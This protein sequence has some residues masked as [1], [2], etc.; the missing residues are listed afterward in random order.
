MGKLIIIEGGDG[1]G[2]ATQ[3]RKLWQRLADEGLQVKKVEFPNYSSPSSS[4]V[5]MYLGGEFGTDPNAVNPYAASTFYAVDRYAS[6]KTLWGDFYSR[7][8]IILSDR[9]TTSN[10]I[11]Q[12]VKIK[13]PAGWA[14]YLDWLK[15][16]EYRLMGLPEPD[17]VIYLNMPPDLSIRFIAGR[18]DKSSVTSQDIHEKNKGYLKESYDNAQ[19][20]RVRE[21]WL[22]IDCVS[23]GRL[24]SIEEIHEEIYAVTQKAIVLK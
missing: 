8:G 5:T 20:V 16:F 11:H 6:Y 19:K 14:S 21:N 24:K 15:D 13:D 18:A 12:A 4:L 23:E 17:L 3:T 22:T 1:S 7:G 10:M 2:K 9:Y